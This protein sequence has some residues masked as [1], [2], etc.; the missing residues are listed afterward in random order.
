MKK[1]MSI[2]IIFVLFL[3]DFDWGH[4]KNFSL[5]FFIWL[6]GHF[7]WEENLWMKGFLLVSKCLDF[8]YL[9]SSYRWIN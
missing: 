5:E 7:V 6:F 9:F 2:E 4:D 1:K 8:N 3:L